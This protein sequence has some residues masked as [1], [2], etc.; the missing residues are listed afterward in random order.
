MPHEH[1][2][3]MDWTTEMPLDV[4]DEA[5]AESFPASDA[6]SWATGKRHAAPT[7]DGA[8]N[9][10][11]KTEAPHPETPPHGENSLA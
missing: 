8:E 9:L 7:A 2:F 1:D 4:V 11:D 5:S 3:T 10:P 6:P